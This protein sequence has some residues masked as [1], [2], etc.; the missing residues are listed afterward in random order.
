[1]TKSRFPK[2]V[3]EDLMAKSGRRCCLCHE[4]K[5]GRLQIHHI[6]PRAEGGKGTPDN[7][8][9][10]CFDC[11]SDVHAYWG[12]THM[13]RSFTAPELKRHRDQWFETFATASGTQIDYEKL[14]GELLHQIAEQARPPQGAADIG[15]EELAK[16]AGPDTAERLREALGLQKQNRE[17]EAIDALYEAFRRDLRPPARA[18]F[19]MLLADSYLSLG[20]L[21]QAMAHYSRGLDVARAFELEEEEADFLLAIGITDAQRGRTASAEKCFGEARQLFRRI[22]KRALEGAVLGNLGIFHMEQD[23]LDLAEEELKEALR[24]SQQLAIKQSEAR[25]LAG[26][27]LVAHKR[28]RYPRAVSFHQQALEINRQLRSRRSESQ[29]LANLAIAYLDSN[30]LELAERYLDESLE[31]SR[32]IDDRLT[33]GR[34]LANL[35]V[36]AM[37]RRQ[38]R[39]ACSS[40]REAVVIFEE[41][42]AAADANRVRA[43][44]QRLGC[45]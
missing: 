28:K 1:M 35:G 12:K 40:F 30:E 8:I 36:L 34:Q 25:V 17:R 37:R 3:A 15:T 27:G 32:E 39:Q 13:G 41:T 45:E 4:F 26:L 2:S 38:A 6:T 11:H 22:G 33:E 9:V 43:E 14:A 44:L 20:D 21:N 24:V 10:I 29:D 5:G 19:H 18:Q 7:G 23:R 42:G 16:A 31:I